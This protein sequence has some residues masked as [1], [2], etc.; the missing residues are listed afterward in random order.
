MGAV[1]SRSGGLLDVGS[2]AVDESPLSTLT[3]ISVIGCVMFP[4]FKSRTLYYKQILIGDR[5][6]VYQRMCKWFHL[7]VIVDRQEE[8]ESEEDAPVASQLIWQQKMAE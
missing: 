8:A 1:G 7:E 4:I 6:M 3:R 5:S 2:V